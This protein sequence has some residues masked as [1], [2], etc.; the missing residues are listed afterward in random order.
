[1]S[2]LLLIGAAVLLAAI[3]GAKAASRLGLPS[4]LLFLALGMAMGYAGIAFNDANF[5][6]DIGFAALVLILT[7]G[8]LTTRWQTIKPALGAAVLLATVGIGVSV[9]VVAVGAHFLFNIPWASAVLIGAALSPTDS[10]AVFSVLRHLPLPRRATSVLEA[11]SGLNDA[12][13][14]LLVAA[15]TAY[16]I[17]Q[18]PAGGV[19]GILGMM[20]FE[21]IGGVAVGIAL[22]VLG[23]LI[24]RG[25]ALPASGLYPL[26]TL[27]WAVLAYGL[28]DW[29]HVSAFAAVYVC[30]VL[31]GN[32]ALP[33]RQA[34]KSFVEGIGW[35]AQIG[36]F[37]MLGLLAAPVT[38]NWRMI[39]AGLG[40]GAVLTFV[41][42]PLSVH[43]SLL[44]FR[45]PWR[46]QMF[47]AWAGLRGAVPI[48]M[49]TVP[50]AAHSPHAK[51]LFDDVF[52]AVVVFTLVQ[53]PTLGWVARRL[54]LVGS[55]VANDIDIDSAPLSNVAAELLHF[56]VPEGSKLGGVSTSEL[57]LP[58]GAVLSVIVRDK[59]PFTPTE[60]TIIRSGDELLIV[61]GAHM[62]N[63]LEERIREVD[64][65]GR[66]AGWRMGS[67]RR[68]TLLAPSSK[69]RGAR[70]SSR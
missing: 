33:H 29:M 57:R 23:V 42:R 59:E 48:I 70:T 58:R 37:V 43:L 1:M 11:E 60:H 50:M 44:P 6:H 17:N 52:I 32:G 63:A 25:L 26:A 54:G 39:L 49:A 69:R 68:A 4:L 7:E 55:A 53:A 15:A 20:A 9:A 41:A 66:L 67:T 14:V 34:T 38:L 28:G 10:A 61:V 65:E 45:V 36:L 22:G 56:E 47:V 3:G 51:V 13:T 24:M 2:Q 30:S 27:G 31:L 8:G 64:A 12:P 16:T 19:V 21:L 5:A 46:E 62:R 35:I 18:P 40:I